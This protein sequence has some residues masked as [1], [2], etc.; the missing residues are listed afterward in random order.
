MK[1]FLEGRL[2]TE[3][4]FEI[5]KNDECV[6]N[7]LI[8]DKKNDLPVYYDPEFLIERVDLKKLRAK[9]EIFWLVNRYF[10]RNKI[11]CSPNNAD[12]KFFSFLCKIQPSWLE[13]EDEDFLLNIIN[14]TPQNFNKNQKIKYCREKIKSLFKYENK[15]PKWLQNPEWPIVNGKPLIFQYQTGDVDDQLVPLIQYYFYNPDTNENTVITQ[16]T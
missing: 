11:E 1:D 14:S 3:E 2:T 6:R 7:T 12:E 4:F 10:V 13:I 16:F 15:P 9:V 5:Y 8:E